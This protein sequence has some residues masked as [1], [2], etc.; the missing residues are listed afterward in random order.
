MLI[1]DKFDLFFCLFLN[2]LTLL[3]KKGNTKKKDEF[4][5]CPKVKNKI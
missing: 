4:D 2:T 3:K 5:A 1:S